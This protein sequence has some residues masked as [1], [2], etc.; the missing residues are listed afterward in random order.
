[1]NLI[2]VLKDKVL[3]GQHITKDEAL[4]L[5]NLEENKQISELALAA[6]EIRKHFMGNTIDLCSIINAKSGNCSENCSFCSQSAH[7]NSDIETYKY[8]DA[9]TAIAKAKEA[10]KNG[11]KSFGLVVADRTLSPKNFDHILGVMKRIKEEVDIEVDGSLGFISDEQAKRLKQMGVGMINHNLETSESHFGEICTTHSW[12]ER[13]ETLRTLKRH[14]IPVCSGGI[15]GLGESL[16]DRV[17][18]ALAL[19]EEAVKMIP[20]NILDARPGTPLENQKKVSP[21]EVIKTI[22]VFRFINPEAVIKLAGGREGG[23]EDKQQQAFEAGADSLLI[24][25]YLTTMGNKIPE[26]FQMVQNAGFEIDIDQNNYNEIM[27]SGRKG[28]AKH[29]TAL[30][31]VT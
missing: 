15:L 17:E 18:L 21:L 20:I 28:T 30:V 13:L 11:A 3:S 22:A 27:E 14:G 31:Q 9:E 10:K 29:P 16:E 24:G 4:E 5:I 26:D 25:G 19:K 12:Q 2:Q 1:M 7:F 6:N 8:I 23:L